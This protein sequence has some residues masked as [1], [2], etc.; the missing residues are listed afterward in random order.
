MTGEGGYIYPV[1]L[2]SKRIFGRVS[3][4]VAI[5]VRANSSIECKF[6]IANCNEIKSYARP[7]NPRQVWESSFWEWKIVT[8]FFFGI[9]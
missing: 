1:I 5:L 8:V 7:N 6:A 3:N 4:V 9:I 2:S